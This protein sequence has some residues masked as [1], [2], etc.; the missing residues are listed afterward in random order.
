MNQKSPQGTHFHFSFLIFFQLCTTLC[1]DLLVFDV[2]GAG[3]PPTLENLEN[4]EIWKWTFWKIFG[5]TRAN[6]KWTEKVREEWKSI[7]FC[8]HHSQSLKLIFSLCGFSLFWF[9]F[10][11]YFVYTYPCVDWKLDT[12][13]S[14]FTFF[15][16][17]WMKGQEKKD[18]NL[19]KLRKKFRSKVGTLI[20]SK[21]CLS[22]QALLPQP[23]KSRVWIQRRMCVYVHAWKPRMV[24]SFHVFAPR[25]SQLRICGIHHLLAVF[26][27]WLGVFLFFSVCYLMVSG[28]LWLGVFWLFGVSNISGKNDLDKSFPQYPGA[29]R[30]MEPT[31]HPHLWCGQVVLAQWKSALRAKTEFWKQ[32][33][34]FLSFH[35]LSENKNACAW[36]CSFTL[37]FSLRLK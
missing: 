12:T 36:F 5:K 30:R 3:F 31:G 28:Y 34:Y 25:A 9:S 4:L 15:S 26:L 35:G 20:S 33:I 32:L 23:H 19:G 11:A 6:Q 21:R 7:I 14:V 2:V 10:D 27:L 29:S 24:S 1:M 8:I 18:N 22:L 13:T 17:Q 16:E 37:F